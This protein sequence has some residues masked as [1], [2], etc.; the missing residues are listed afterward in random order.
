[1]R[2]LILGS[3]GRT[4]KLVTHSAIA[5]NHQVTA[6]I[7]DKSHATLPKVKHLE[8]SPT[9]PQLLNKALQGVDAVVVSLNINRTSDNP[10]AKVTSP[11]ALIS[12]SVR[13][14]I[15]AMEHNNVKRIIT[16]SAAG[17]GDS[18]KNMPLVARLLIR[19]SNIWK[20]YEDHDRQEQ[21]LQ[22]SKLDWTIVRPVMLNNRDT[23]DY[24]ASIGKPSG[25]SISRKGVATFIIDALE[26]EK[27]MG[28]YVTLFS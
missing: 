13:A 8:G 15:P 21:L 28:D 14:L 7:R 24:R 6:I 27:Y 22:Q 17:V 19:H 12:D 1:M 3:T 23:D 25:S 11:L 4:G 16:V 18:F 26:S 10:F 5:R 9:D 20:A 2:I